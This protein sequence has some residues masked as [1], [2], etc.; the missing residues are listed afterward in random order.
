MYTVV[1]NGPLGDDL[2]TGVAGE[3]ARTVEAA[4]LTAV[5]GTVGLDLFGDAALR[6]NLEDLDWLEEVARAHDAVVGAVADTADTVPIRLATVCP[7]DDRVRSLLIERRSDFEA[8][9]RQIAGRA[10]WGV[11]AVA[12]TT[13]PPEDAPDAGGPGAGARYLARRRAALSSRE[14][15]ERAVEAEADDVHSALLQIAA[16]GRRQRPTAPVLAGTRAWMPLNGTYLVDRARADEFAAAVAA[17][18]DTHQRLRLDLTGPWPPY[19]FTGID[20]VHEEPS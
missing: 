8:A 17:L 20:D 3:R 14:S 15:I 10:E 12:D 7:D 18:Q 6:H 2:P 16:G 9:L 13:A 5:V 4:G 11:R 19:S 1:G